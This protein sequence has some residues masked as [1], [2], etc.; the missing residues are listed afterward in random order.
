MYYG[1]PTVHTSLSPRSCINDSLYSADK[2]KG[3]YFKIQANAPARSAYSAQDV[4][5][6]RLKDERDQAITEDKARQKGRIRRATLDP[7]TDGVLAREYGNGGGLDGPAVFA[8]GLVS[9]GYCL[10]QYGPPFSLVFAVHQRP[11]L[12]PSMIDLR[13][14]EWLIHLKVGRSYSLLESPIPGTI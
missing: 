10:E 2:D 11:D 14:C 9:Q 12:G 4:K 5:R 13:T 6:R 8:K 7:L 1:N 3:K